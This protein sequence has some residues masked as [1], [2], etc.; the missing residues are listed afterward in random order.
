M[1]HACAFCSDDRHT[2]YG[3]LTSTPE[4]ALFTQPTCHTGPLCAP[5]T[6]LLETIM[7][8]VGSPVE[9]ACDSIH[10]YVYR[11]Y[12]YICM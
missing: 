5:G 4:S 1:R 6:K 7:G 8:R 2:L 11:E 3:P 10:I 12:S 9:R